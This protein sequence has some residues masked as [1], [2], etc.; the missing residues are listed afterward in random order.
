VPADD[1]VADTHDE[2]P[3]DT[4]GDTAPDPADA[5]EED[6]PDASDA[7]E[8]EAL[9][10]TECERAGGACVASGTCVVCPSSMEPSYAERGCGPGNWCC[11][12][13]GTVENPC[14][15]AGGVCLPLTSITSCPPGWISS[16]L[17]CGMGASCCVEG[18][19][20]P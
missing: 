4:A 7:E 14:T 2:H 18:D 16:G 13:G 1:A 10:T 11:V 8:E 12:P 17:A 19:L 9:T 3:A 20:C 15:A 6:A 5:V